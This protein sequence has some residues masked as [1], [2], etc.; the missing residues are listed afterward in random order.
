MF[1]RFERPHRGATFLPMQTHAH[2]QRVGAR[3]AV[4]ALAVCL[5]MLCLLTGCNSTSASSED[6]STNQQQSQGTSFVLGNLNVTIYDQEIVYNTDQKK[7]LAI[8]ARVTNNGTASESVMG[9]YNVSRN[10]G[11]G[12]HLKVAV[13]Y[14]TNGNALHTGYERISPGESADIAL[15]FVLANDNPVTITFGNAERGVKE[16]TLTIPLPA[17][18]E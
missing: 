2:S 16:T 4:L 12:T 6:T 18:D 13:A 9:S 17:G 14:D 11:A 5:G 3:V 15:C 7:C 8:Y 1:A 10:Q